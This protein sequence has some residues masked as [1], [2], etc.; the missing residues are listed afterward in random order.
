[1][2]G[3]KKESLCGN[4][5]QIFVRAT[6]FEEKPGFIV[7]LDKYD[8]RKTETEMIANALTTRGIEQ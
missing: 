7:A 3:S 6:G 4:L 1:M 2:R 8:S 5:E